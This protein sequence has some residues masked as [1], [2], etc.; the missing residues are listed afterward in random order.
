MNGEAEVNYIEKCWADLQPG[1]QLAIL[2][3]ILVDRIRNLPRHMREA[4]AREIMI[5][6]EPEAKKKQSARP[7]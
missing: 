5:G 7:S 3:I 4:A 2:E 6:L 1:A